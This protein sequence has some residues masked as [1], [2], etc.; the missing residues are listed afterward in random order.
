MTMDDRPNRPGT[1]R[2]LVPQTK[3]RAL[4]D[5]SRV[6]VQLG[7]L[8]ASRRSIRL[9]G[10]AAAVAAILCLTTV[11]L[12][13][14]RLLAGPVSFSFLV[15]TLQNQLNSQLQGYSFHASD[16]FLRLSSGWRLEFRLADVRLLDESNQEI[17]KAPFASIGISERSLLK[18]SLAASR[19]SLLGPKLLVFNSPGKGLTL[20]APPVSSEASEPAGPSGWESGE[21]LGEAPYADLAA[22]ERMRDAAGS[23]Q[24][25]QPMAERFNPAPLL[26]RLFTALKARG[27]ASS[28][29]ERIGVKNAQIFFASE[30]GVSTWRIDDFHIDLEEG[31]SESALRGELT[32]GEEG[33]AWRASFRAVNQPARRLYSL[34]ASISD[35][36]PRT[37]WQSFPIFDAL[38]LADIPVSGEAR[39]DI[40]HEGI[41]VGGEGEIKLGSGK[42]FSAH[43]P[44]PAE[45]DGGLLKVSYDK[46]SRTLSI[47]P[48][49]LRW[50]DSLLTLSGTVAYLN[51]AGTNQ[52]VLLAELDGTGTTLGAP[53][54]GV[55]SFPL[56]TFKI[57]ASYQGATDTVTLKEFTVAA[58]GGSIAVNGQASE[59]TSGGPIKLNGVLS[60]MQLV[61]LKAF[62]PAFHL[63]WHP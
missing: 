5:P 52:P 58:G 45:I 63:K 3:G 18:F 38:K 15:P 60:P 27:G 51:D 25:A 31:G 41:L 14:A 26:S 36:V 30:K 47:K 57:S 23:V 19:I 49:E 43:D 61:P 24:N 62:W 46:A 34:T 37:I 7:R 22:K 11:V 6:Q 44:R 39:F 40:S 9:G 16:A 20:T 48:L 55:P 54:F 50:D 2:A 33:S 28:A 12:L 29:L 56:D 59:V 8:S 42:F 10:R 53:Q 21:P 32:L 17:A 13:Y 1:R 35:I 4:D